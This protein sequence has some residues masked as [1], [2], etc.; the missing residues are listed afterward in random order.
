MDEPQ[1][2]PAE[3]SH[4]SR[5][6]S[7][8]LGRRLS[9]D[10]DLF[11]HR[12]MSAPPRRSSLPPPYL[13]SKSPLQDAAESAQGNVMAQS[14]SAACNVPEELPGY[15]NSVFLEGIFSK[16]HEIENTTKRAED[17]RW[18]NA[19]VVLHGTALHVYHVKK[20]WGWGKTR[21]GPSICP[22]NPPWVKKSKLEKTYS[23]LHADAGIAADYR[24]CVA[25]LNILSQPT[26]ITLRRRYVIRIRA[27]TDQFLLSCIELGTFVKWLEALFAAIDIAAPIDEREFPRDMSIPRVQRIRWFRGQSPVRMP[28]PARTQ[29]FEEPLQP[30]TSAE[31]RNSSPRRLRSPTREQEPEIVSREATGGFPRHEIEHEV[32]P[33]QNAIDS[34]SEESEDED[35]GVVSR[36]HRLVHRLS[37]TSYHNTSIDPFSGKWFPEHK[38]SEAHDMLYAKLCYS[39]LLF[40]S[41]RRSNYIISKG[42]Q[43]FVDWATG[44]MVRVLPPAYGEDVCGPWQAVHTENPRI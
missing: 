42:K 34:D 16:K 28:S 44:R 30:T 43:W 27:E 26:N 32:E 24:K 19:F 7:P 36:G 4:A 20:D 3:D 12:I 22:D 1:E 35:G 8:P 5:Q 2:P 33:A 18:H 21:D 6:G 25:L 38:W 41:P 15:S 13:P 17:R 11:Y 14:S 31:R 37:T 40:R 29:D 39:N 23:L 10:E 9:I